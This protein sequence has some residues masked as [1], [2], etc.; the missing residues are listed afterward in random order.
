MEKKYKKYFKNNI[1]LNLS[2]NGLINQ[3]ELFP[4]LGEEDKKN[5]ENNFKFYNP[6]KELLQ[7]FDDIEI[8]LKEAINP[9]LY[10]YLNRKKIH[11]ILYDVNKNI[12][13]TKEMMKDLTDFIYLYLLINDDTE[14]V[15]YKYNFDIVEKAGKMEKEA[16]YGITKIILC[17]I[18]KTLIKNYKDSE[19]VAG[20]EDEKWTKLDNYYKDEIKANK[21]GLKDYRMDIDL[22]KLYDEDKTGIEVIYS[23]I[24]K[25]LI[26]EDKLN[27][28]NETLGF[29]EE[30]EIKD[31][32]LTPIIVN[33]L[34]KVFD[35][36]KNIC[37]YKIENFKDLE[38]KKKLIFYQ[39]L[40]EYILKDSIY[41]DYIPFLTKTR[42]SI[43]EIIRK[44][45]DYFEEE[46]KKTKNEKTELKIVLCYFI[47]KNYLKS[48][49]NS[50]LFSSNSYQAHEQSR[51]MKDNSNDNQSG[52]NWKPFY[53]NS[54]EN[55]SG[56]GGGLSSYEIC[57]EMQVNLINERAYQ[58]L[59]DSTFELRIK[60]GDNNI[61][62]SIIYKD[63]NGQN[64]KISIEDVRKEVSADSNLNEKYQKFK[65]YLDTVEKEFKSG[66][67]GDKEM[68]LTM[69]F[70]M[71]KSLDCLNCQ[72]TIKDN[73][74][75]EREFRDDNIFKNNNHNGLFAARNAIN[76]N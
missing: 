65:D 63:K 28:S 23:N 30:L 47:E 45:N 59:F 2:Y 8:I 70:N 68:K 43:I 4:V 21:D 29:L 53:G 13:I 40:F 58:I 52:G 37:E 50:D 1:R 38:N 57:D 39:M 15:N 27:L 16:K 24:I 73:S 60:K 26:T 20:Y 49:I 18:I 11:T 31:L 41:I 22:D 46:F 69:R 9:M 6:F 61:F 42:Q 25:R 76:G 32:R 51:E 55:R 10:L 44:N 3:Y 66:Y 12:F 75:N 54:Y 56:P 14:L 74:I 34:L 64:Q 19:D 35:E 72:F 36:E 48:I 7:N 17:K 67:E 33:G 62:D 71:E 5:N